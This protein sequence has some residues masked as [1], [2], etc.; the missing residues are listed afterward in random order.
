[1]ATDHIAAVNAYFEAFGARDMDRILSYF[2]PGA[3]WTIPGDQAMTPWVGRRIGPEEIRKSLAAFF[4]A[5]E[6]LEFELQTMTEAD[7]RV[8]VPGHYASR[9]HPSGQVLESE[10]VLRF[11]V[12][13]GLI[14]DYRVFEDSLGITRAY[15]GE[16]VITSG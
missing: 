16:P 9:F 5:V 14:T 8:F 10:L 12:V 15:C 3:T 4:E 6:P 13:D 11:A 2:A 7:G 1:M